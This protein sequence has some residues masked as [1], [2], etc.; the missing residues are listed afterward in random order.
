VGL[1]LCYKTDRGGTIDGKCQLSNQRLPATL[2]DVCDGSTSTITKER[3][4]NEF[5]FI[6]HLKCSDNGHEKGATEQ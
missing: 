6:V 5:V 2:H 4:V 1:V 3:S